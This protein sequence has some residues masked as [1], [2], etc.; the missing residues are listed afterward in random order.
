MHNIASQLFYLFV[1]ARHAVPVF[2]L[3]NLKHLNFFQNEE[4]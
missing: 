1:G 3:L 4:L 2:E